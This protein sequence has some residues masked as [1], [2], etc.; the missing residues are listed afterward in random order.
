MPLA[1]SSV[2]AIVRDRLS[3]WDRMETGLKLLGRQQ[4]TIFV[5]LT[6]FLWCRR[7]SK[8]SLSYEPRS[9]V[10][11][12]FFP[13]KE[14]FRLL[15]LKILLPFFLVP[16]NNTPNFKSSKSSLSLYS[17][18]ILMFLINI[19]YTH[20]HIYIHMYIYIFKKHLIY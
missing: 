16:K 20:T 11:F 2:V 6:R 9:R 15:H 13:Q 12:C 19:H 10:S 8:V 17:L 5:L 1:S 18:K 4:G 14:V 7:M 3:A